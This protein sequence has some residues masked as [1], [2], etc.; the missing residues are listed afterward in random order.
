M[1]QL[2]LRRV[3]L[4]IPLLALVSLIVFSLLLL[5]P[6]DPATAILGDQATP[7]QIAVTRERLGLN[8]PFPVRY[9]QW[10]A[11]AA[12]GD[13]GTSLFNSYPVT[14]AIRD[15]LPVT[16]SLVGSSLLLTV[17]IGIPAGILAGARHG[18][19]LDRI[20]TFGTSAGI[21]IPNFWLGIVLALFVGIKLGWFPATGYVPMAESASGWLRHLILPAVTL[22]AASTAELTRQMRSSMIDVMEQDY[23]R[24]ARSKGLSEYRVVVAHALKNAMIPVVTVAGLS[25]SRTFGLSVIVEQIFNLQGVGSLALHAVFDRDL[26]LIQGVVMVATA[27]VLVTNFLVD[28]SYIYF[29][30]ST[31]PR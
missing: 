9:A 16:L 27:V 7:Q 13:L 17:L 4:L 19:W 14:A 30:P 1:L 25:V 24:T 18:G 12:R 31:R 23:I 20:L 11:N 8:E 21:A 28:L 26:P 3:G 10:A 6:G 15:R 2:A 22:A 29:N 5:I